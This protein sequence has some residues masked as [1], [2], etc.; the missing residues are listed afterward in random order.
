MKRY[1]AA[2]VGP[3]MVNG[4]RVELPEA[5][6]QA[7]AE[8]WNAEETARPER[9]WRERMA[10]SDRAITA[11]MIED[12]AVAVG[13]EKLPEDLQ[14]AVTARQQLRAARPGRG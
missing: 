13:L 10:A 12:L 14:A 11:R 3:R 4:R 1:T 8:A 6:R 5:E 2:D 9:E 7:I